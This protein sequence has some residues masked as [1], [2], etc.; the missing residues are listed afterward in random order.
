MMIPIRSGPSSGLVRPS[1]S[2]LFVP[3][4]LPRSPFDREKKVMCSLALL[5]P[6]RFALQAE[7]IHH[8]IK[9]TVFEQGT[10]ECLDSGFMKFQAWF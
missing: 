2:A 4:T 8:S 6:S 1:V 10:F 9:S 5:R 7:V 3:L